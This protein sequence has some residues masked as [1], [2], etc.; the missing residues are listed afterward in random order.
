MFETSA[1]FDEKSSNG[2]R[3]AFGAFKATSI[4]VIS[5]ILIP[6]PLLREYGF[7]H[8][9][10]VNKAAKQEI[11]KL[12]LTT[13][14]LLLS[15]LLLTYFVSFS[16]LNSFEDTQRLKFQK[17]LVVGPLLVGSL[18]YEKNQIFSFSRLYS[19]H[20][21]DRFKADLKTSRKFNLTQ[22]YLAAP[23][24]L[25]LMYF[26]VKLN[27]IAIGEAFIF[28]TAILGFDSLLVGTIAV[29]LGA[30]VTRSFCYATNIPVSVTPLGSPYKSI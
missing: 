3:L 24:C 13:F 8:S 12:L 14:A 15:G 28:Q 29:V 26:H 4:I 18:L 27:Q 11:L 5:M 19:D 30:A 6:R 10:A 2:F 7:T 21:S 1:A 23:I 17:L 22:L 25:P 16:V 20:R 9:E